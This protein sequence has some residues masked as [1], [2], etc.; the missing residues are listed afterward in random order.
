[1]NPFINL[2]LSSFIAHGLLDFYTF[3]S[4]SDL[5]FYIC[6][7]VV[8]FYIMYVLP[9]LGVF[10]FVMASMYHFG[11]DF[12]YF[13]QSV[14]SGVVLFSTSYLFYMDEWVEVAR[15]LSIQHHELFILLLASFIVPGLI[16]SFHKFIGLF[17]AVVIGACG[18]IG[19]FFY[20]SVL[21]APLGVYRFNNSSC[22]IVW[23]LSTVCIMIVLPTV[24]LYM[25]VVKASISLVMSHV[26]AI[27]IWQK[28]THV[29]S[30]TIVIGSK[31]VM[32][33]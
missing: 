5:S 1:M 9:S 22:Y 17:V 20:M 7:M 8:Y 14:W 28:E 21:H 16:G 31:D 11:E 23:M 18:P 10:G 4:A 3:K 24:Q 13:R 30:S 2:L 26:V 15:E 19:L 32:A 29:V 12:K 6:F 25:W 27:S 33:V